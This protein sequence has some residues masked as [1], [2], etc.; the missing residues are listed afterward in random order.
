ML[1]AAMAARTRHKDPAAI[2]AAIVKRVAQ[3]DDMKYREELD[4]PVDP[5]AIKKHT[6]LVQDLLAV[7]MGKAM[8]QGACSAAYLQVATLKEAEWHLGCKAKKWAGKA[9]KRTRAML[10]DVTQALI[11]AR[12][13]GECPHSWL[14]PFWD[15]PEA[16]EAIT[17][18]SIHTFTSNRDRSIEFEIQSVEKNSIETSS[19]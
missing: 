13:A 12:R 6:A 14:Q 11:K 16:I 17:M 4:G 15:K 7:T 8:T 5:Q 3:P 1:H 18:Y 19:V 9:S 2:A 10:R